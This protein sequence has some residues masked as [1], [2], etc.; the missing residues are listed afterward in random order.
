MWMWWIIR[1]SSQGWFPFFSFLFY[2]VRFFVILSSCTTFIAYIIVGQRGGIQKKF[3]GLVLSFYFYILPTSTTNISYNIWVR[4]GVWGLERSSQGWFLSLF[5]N[6]FTVIAYIIGG[7]REEIQN[8]FSKPIL[9]FLFYIKPHILRWSHLS[10]LIK[11]MI[12]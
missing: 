9:S 2:L 3:S 1:R 4:R 6:Y 5:L 10:P 11:P 12:Y 8:K 7:Q